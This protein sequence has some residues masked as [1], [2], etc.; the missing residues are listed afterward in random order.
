M[1]RGNKACKMNS[2]L[3]RVGRKK[4]HV[5]LMYNRLYYFTAPPLK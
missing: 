3:A 4:L 5:M 2:V 1:R